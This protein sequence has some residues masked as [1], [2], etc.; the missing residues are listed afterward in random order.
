MDLTRSALKLW[1]ES[2]SSNHPVDRARC[3]GSEDQMTE[4]GFFFFVL[5]ESRILVFL[6]AGR[7][8]TKEGWMGARMSE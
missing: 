5:F 3:H 2:S 8:E 7:P 6:S 4:N 1:S